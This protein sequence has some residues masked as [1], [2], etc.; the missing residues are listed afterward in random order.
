MKKKM[1]KMKKKPKT[2]PKKQKQKKTACF[3]LHLKIIITFLK[4]NICIL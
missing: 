3:V 1:K 2:K 4:N